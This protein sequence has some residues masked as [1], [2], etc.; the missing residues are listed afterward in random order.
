MIDKGRR[1]FF[2]KF[3]IT[4]ALLATSG[5]VLSLRK[6]EASIQ[7]NIKGLCLRIPNS[8]E[9]GAFA[10]RIKQSAP[11]SWKVHTLRGSLTDF[12]FETRALYEEAKN[13]VNTFVGAADPAS[14]AVIREAIVDSGGSFHYITHEDPHKV[15]FS[16]RV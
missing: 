16:A 9:G 6:A 10:D 4:G 11:G 8:H 14:F 1:D 3:A 2:K 13:K 5:E 12:Y 15:C 7:A